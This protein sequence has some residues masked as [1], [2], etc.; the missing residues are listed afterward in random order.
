MDIAIFASDVLGL[1]FLESN[2]GG[3]ECDC[4]VS[5]N[6]STIPGNFGNSTGEKEKKSN[7]LDRVVA[8]PTAHTMVPARRKDLRRMAG[9]AL[10]AGVVMEVMEPPRWDGAYFCRLRLLLW[11]DRLVLERSGAIGC[12]EPSENIWCW[13]LMALVGSGKHM[14]Q[15]F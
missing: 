14:R 8:A 3:E 11:R 6:G 2:G 5:W 15:D 12:E 4:C 10:A 7:G 9:L 13:E 1:R